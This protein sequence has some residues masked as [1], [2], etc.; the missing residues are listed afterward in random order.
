MV[1]RICKICNKEIKS[2]PYSG[3]LYLVQE[4]YISEQM[5]SVGGFKWYFHP[6][7]YELKHFWKVIMEVK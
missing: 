5:V 2:E 4:S 7:C 6:S 3:K 1:I